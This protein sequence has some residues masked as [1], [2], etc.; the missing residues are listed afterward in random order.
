MRSKLWVV[1]CAFI[2]L[3]SYVVESMPSRVCEDNGSSSSSAQEKR[4]LQKE[5]DPCSLEQSKKA[6]GENRED[7][8]EKETI[9]AEQLLSL[10]RSEIARQTTTLSHDST[11][12][13]RAR[14]NFL[15]SVRNVLLWRQCRNRTYNRVLVLGMNME[16][17]KRELHILENEMNALDS[18]MERSKR[19]AITYFF[20][21]K[22]AQRKA[23]L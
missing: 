21:F 13:I 11:E 9:A 18:N 14:S 2:C 19:E 22:K 16:R 10:C 5:S 12:I 7:S 23:K 17:C 20:Q 4:P 3:C 15:S 8:H 6:C 1:C